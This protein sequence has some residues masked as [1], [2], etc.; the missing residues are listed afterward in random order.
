MLA[1]ISQAAGKENPPLSE[2]C[3]EVVWRV[4]IAVHDISFLYTRVALGR[5]PDLLTCP[6]CS[7]P[8]D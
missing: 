5:N 3:F 6:Y 7:A 2:A 8:R 4:R 1:E